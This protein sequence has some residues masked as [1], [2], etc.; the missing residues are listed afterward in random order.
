MSKPMTKYLV[1]QIRTAADEM[2]MSELLNYLSEL[3]RK[4]RIT[5]NW[6]G[7][8]TAFEFAMHLVNS[9]KESLDRG[10]W[11]G[12]EPKALRALDEIP[13]D[14]SIFVIIDNYGYPQE[15]DNNDRFL[16]VLGVKDQLYVLKG[17]AA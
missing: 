4:D 12:Y 5:I 8:D 11:Y 10:E 1:K 14:E 7:W 9:M 2:S 6:D 3:E 16:E 13:G 15:I 17:G